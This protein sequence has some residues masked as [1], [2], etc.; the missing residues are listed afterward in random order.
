MPISLS[1][2]TPLL[3]IILVGGDDGEKDFLLIGPDKVRACVI[4]SPIKF[5]L[6][7]A[8]TSVLSIVGDQDR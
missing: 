2:G 3:T 7:S 5:V 1:T 6:Y 4:Q 8:C